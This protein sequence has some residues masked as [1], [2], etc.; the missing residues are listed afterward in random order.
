MY[1]F[2]RINSR[3]IQFFTS[4]QSLFYK[5]E[6]TLC[7]CVLHCANQSLCICC[8]QNVIKSDFFFV[9]NCA[10]RVWRF[11]L[12]LT[13]FIVLR[14]KCD[15]IFLL[16]NFLYGAQAKPFSWKKAY[17][18]NVLCKTDNF[19]VPFIF[20]T[21]VVNALFMEQDTTVAQC[22]RWSN[23]WTFMVDYG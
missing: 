14:L 3:F 7:Y 16:S 4:V 10:A 1:L 12:D 6:Q 22:G 13:F 15:I 21:F 5:I 8:C 20:Q 23:D 17:W 19:Y 11:C 18:E 2:C 9:F